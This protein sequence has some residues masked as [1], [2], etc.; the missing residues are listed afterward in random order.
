M[1]GVPVRRLTGRSRTLRC[2]KIEFLNGRLSGKLVTATTNQIMIVL[3]HSAYMSVN[4][5][6]SKIS[7]K[8][9]FPSESVPRVM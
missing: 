2:P 8:I 5:F 1:H 6:Q 4:S 7:E 3:S 9:P